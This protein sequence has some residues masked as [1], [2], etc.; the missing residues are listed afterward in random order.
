MTV[1]EIVSDVSAGGTQY[2]KK[3]LRMSARVWIDTATLKNNQGIALFTDND[4]VIFYVI[5][6][7]VSDNLTQY[8]A[9]STY[10]FF[11]LSVRFP[12][13]RQASSQSRQI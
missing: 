12:K 1:A 8:A 2:L 3:T 9:N 4:N 13:T 7:D 10:E 11:C 6:P 5:D